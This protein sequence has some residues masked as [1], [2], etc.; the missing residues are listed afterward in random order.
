MHVLPPELV[1]NRC[2]KQ[3]LSLKNSV[4]ARAL[5]GR[6]ISEATSHARK[7]N[8]RLPATSIRA[9]S[10][11]WGTARSLADLGY[12]HGE[13]G[14]CVAA[15]AA[16]RQALEI[17]SEL[18]HRRGI[19]R[20]LEGLACLAITQGQLARDIRSNS[21]ERLLE[22]RRLNESA[23]C[24]NP[25]ERNTYPTRVLTNAILIRSQINAIHL[26][27]GHI[28]V[29]LLNLRPHLLPYLQGTQ[30][31]LPNLRLG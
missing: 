5:P 11:P 10:R 1:R 2:G 27:L 24:G 30:G 8:W 17:F 3:T 4:I 29:E 28:A 21:R 7:A 6:S 14:D 13:L 16:Y 19:A 12:I 9:R 20:A 25:V 26:V 31:E 18:G 23:N 22:I 15:Q